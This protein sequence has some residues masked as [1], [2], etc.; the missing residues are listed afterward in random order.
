MVRKISAYKGDELASWK[1]ALCED[2]CAGLVSS[3]MV[4][5]CSLQSPRLPPG[6]LAC[7]WWV[8]WTLGGKLGVKDQLHK[9]RF[10]ECLDM[11]FQDSP[12]LLFGSMFMQS[13]HPQIN[14]TSFFC[15]S[16]ISL[17][18]DLSMKGPRSVRKYEGTKWHYTPMQLIRYGFEVTKPDQSEGRLRWPHSK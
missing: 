14:L 10:L 17:G 4:S 13:T 18:E 5:H 2:F 8:H 3:N 1:R 7:Q 16:S 9:S 6:F 15:C 11:K 12:A